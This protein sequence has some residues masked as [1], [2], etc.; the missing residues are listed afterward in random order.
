M[1]YFLAL[2]P[3]T[4][5]AKQI[6]LFRAEWGPIGLPAHIT[7]KAPNS[8]STARLWLPQVQAFCQGAAPV[9]VCLD[10]IGQFSSSVVY[11]RV[12]SAGVLALHQS[13]LAII[14]PPLA[15]RTVF[16][17]GPA[18]VPHL[19]L[20]HLSER[21]NAATLTSVHQCASERWRQPVDF[22]AQIVRVYRSSGTNQA[23]EPYLDV[24]LAGK[25]VA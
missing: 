10:G 24:P 16:F 25:S 3:P 6:D 7:V 21:M 14:N 20:A 18:Y 8:L 23:Y 5:L 17:E 1:K 22:V 15:E 9:P 12:V 11:W 19:T 2:V 13:L 4:E